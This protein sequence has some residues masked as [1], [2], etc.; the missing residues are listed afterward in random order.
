MNR[1]GLIDNIPV[2]SN[3]VDVVL[4]NCVINLA[5]NKNKVYAEIHRILKEGGHFCISD[6]VV[7][8]TLPDKIKQAAIMLA[9]CVAGI[10]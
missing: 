6:I 4:S 5:P 7:S 9:G 10:N 3:K 2:M 1:Q 8:D